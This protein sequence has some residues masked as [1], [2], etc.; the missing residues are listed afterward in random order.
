MVG[1]PDNPDRWFDTWLEG[2]TTTCRFYHFIE[3]I[4]HSIRAGTNGN[5]FA[6]AIDSLNSHDNTVV[7]R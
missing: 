1:D 4:S 2:R 6:L 3:R 5:T 7:Q